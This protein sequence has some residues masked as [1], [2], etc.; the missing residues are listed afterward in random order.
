[1]ANLDPTNILSVT[2][3]WC[4]RDESVGSIEIVQVQADLSVRELSCNRGLGH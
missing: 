4:P 2:Y 3:L 1:M